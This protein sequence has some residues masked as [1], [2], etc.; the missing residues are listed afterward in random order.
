VARAGENFTEK[1]R[2]ADQLSLVFEE[3]GNG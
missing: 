1:K 3:V 2:E